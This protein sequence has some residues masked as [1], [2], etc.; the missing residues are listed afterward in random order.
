MH[1]RHT[2]FRIAA[3]IILLLTGVEL[4]ACEVFSHAA[5]EFSGAPS[6]HSTHSGDDCLCCCFHIVVEA[7]LVFEPTEEAVVLETL[8]PIP[9]SSCESASIYHPPKA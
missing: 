7:P 5:C 8:P 2:I 3:V 4:V 1:S 9:F 6:G